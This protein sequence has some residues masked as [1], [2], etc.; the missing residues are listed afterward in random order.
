[1]CPLKDQIL[2]NVKY[3]ACFKMHSNRLIICDTAV[4][5]QFQT[6]LKTHSYVYS[7]LC[8]WKRSL[9][10]R[11]VLFTVQKTCIPLQFTVH[12]ETF[13]LYQN[14]TL[15]SIENVPPLLELYTVQYIKRASLYSLLYTWKRSPFIRT[16]HC[17]VQKTCIPLKFTV[18]LD[19]LP[20]YQNCTL[21]SIENVHHF[22][23]YCTLGNVPP[24]KELYNV[25]Y[26]KRASLYSLL[27]TWKRSLFIRTVLCTVQ[28]TFPLYQN[29]TLYSIE[30]VHPFT[31]YYALG[32]V[33][34]L[35]ELYTVQYRKRASLYSLLYIWKR[36]SF[37]RTVHC[38]L[39]KNVHPFTV[40]YTL[41]NVSPLI[42]LYT[43]QYRKLATELNS[44]ELTLAILIISV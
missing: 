26:R 27:Y 28:K 8:T 6:Q 12:L 19:T 38:T 39:Q 15:Y 9:F 17:T 11:T 23:V 14:C 44:G 36:F 25:Q 3:P 42:E 22:T 32:N 31:V 21:Y 29:C 30:N 1:M 41:G 33:P 43:V 24:L 35:L 2:E 4:F 34:P 7:L 37:I 40:Y 18:H 10:I 5:I 16:V 20:L 13:P